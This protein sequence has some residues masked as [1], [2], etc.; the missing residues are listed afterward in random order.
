MSLCQSAQFKRIGGFWFTSIIILS[1]PPRYSISHVVV[2]LKSISANVIFREYPGVKKQLWGGEFWEDW[3]FVRTLGDKV[4]AEVIRKYIEYH[5][6]HEKTP[7]QLKL[8]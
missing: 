4:T 1:F 2:M 8:F 5:R 7:E 3:Y 6:H